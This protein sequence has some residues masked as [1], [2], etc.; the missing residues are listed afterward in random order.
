VGE[1][2]EEVARAAH[3][4]RAEKFRRDGGRE[5]RLEKFFREK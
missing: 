3:P 4:F 2:R 1:D 5:N